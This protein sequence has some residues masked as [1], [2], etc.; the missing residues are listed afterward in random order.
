M[1]A[2]VLSQPATPEHWPAVG[3]VVGD[4]VVVV[5]PEPEPEQALTE[6]N[7]IFE[8]RGRGTILTGAPRASRIRRRCLVGVPLGLK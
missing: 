4:V 3:V 1:Y 8:Q 5:P 2:T 7:K 6:E